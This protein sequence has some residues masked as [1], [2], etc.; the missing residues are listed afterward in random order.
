MSKNYSLFLLQNLK[1]TVVEVTV[2]WLMMMLM[3]L[4][5]MWM[6]L[7][8]FIEI[9]ATSEGWV[10]NLQNLFCFV[11]PSFSQPGSE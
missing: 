5:M 11:V 6:L 10:P 4:L 9:T 1:S 3:V 8:L 7:L 2:V